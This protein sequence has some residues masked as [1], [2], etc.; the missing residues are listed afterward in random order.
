MARRLDRQ[1]AACGENGSPLYQRVL[2]G[3]AADCRAGGPAWRVLAGHEDDP[4]GTA[5]PLRLMGAVR[6]LALTGRAADF[7]GA[8]DPWAAFRSVL[9]EHA[10]EVRAHLADPV[11]TNE[12]GRSAAL[13]GAFL[14]VAQR[15]GLPL[16]LLEL[17]ASAGLNLRW[18]RYR[19]E[20][21]DR[22]WGDPRSPVRM[23]GWFPDGTPPFHL[24]AEVAQR[25]GCD[26]HPVDLSSE[27]GRT[28]LLAYVWADQGERLERLRRACEVAAADPVAIDRAEAVGWAA[29]QLARPVA[30]RA[31]VVFHSM[32]L[33]YLPREGRD[34][35]RE[36]IERAGAAA[37]PE[38]PLAWLRME[39]A[40]PLSDVRLA[41]WPGGEDR[42]VARA[43]YHGRPVHWLG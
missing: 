19:Y 34:A 11:Q 7:A 13:I 39:A 26:R 38:A 31:T 43:G 14:L 25:R 23:A 27:A 20:Q 42:L 15:F 5:L 1:A 9:E 29:Q 18:H 6:K 35:L 41:T 8:A 30:G 21:G 36:A 4:G 10:D 16:R 12:P 2:E 24:P 3:A 37:T 40:P 33:Q 22:G 17:G 28:T 32:F